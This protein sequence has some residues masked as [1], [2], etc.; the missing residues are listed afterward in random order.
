[1]THWVKSDLEDFI[2]QEFKHEQVMYDRIE[3]CTSRELFSRGWAV[4][5]PKGIGVWS[6]PSLPTAS[7]LL[8]TSSNC[9]LLNT[10]AGVDTLVLVSVAGDSKKEVC[11]G[12]IVEANTRSQQVVVYRSANEVRSLQSSSD[13]LYLKLE[14]SLGDKKKAM[15]IQSKFDFSESPR[16]TRIF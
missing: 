3:S 8:L 1:M 7:N 4:L 11:G 15:L 5:I 9:G 13:E 2:E 14:V 10:A 12:M 16:A 6:H